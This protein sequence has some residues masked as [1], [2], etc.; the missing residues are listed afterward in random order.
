MKYFSNTLFLFAVDQVLKWYMSAVLP[1]CTP[2]RCD[3]MEVL[4]FFKLMVL[5]NRGAAFSFLAD[6]G[7]WQRWF[8]V[9][10]SSVVSVFV[11]VWLY[12]IRYE[13]KLLAV[14][15]SFILGGALGNLIDRALQGYVVDFFVVYY[16]PYYFPA[17]NIADSAI[18]VGAALMILDILIGNQKRH[19]SE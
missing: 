7:G 18:T 2:E 4:P 9:A 6:A 10:V 11:A 16:H 12:R 13:Q 19:E 3:S 15:L 14:S 17:F 5:H 8:L 1:L